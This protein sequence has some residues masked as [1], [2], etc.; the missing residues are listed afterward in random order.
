MSAHRATGLATRCSACGTVFRVVPDQ[1]RVSEGWVRCG[2][3]SEV[4]NAL[5]GLVDL[6]TGL[7][8]RSLGAGLA[9]AV[10]DESEA[11]ESQ[12]GEYDYAHPAARPG[13]PALAPALASKP[14][15]AVPPPVRH[16]TIQEDDSA[17]NSSL[18]T[19]PDFSTQISAEELAQANA[20]PSFVANADRAALWRRPRVRGVLVLVGLLAAMGLTA[21]VAHEYRNLVAAA[22]PES[23]PWLEQACAALNC[24]VEAAQAIENLAVESS[25][26]VR[27]EKS[28]LYRLQVGLRN[29]AGIDL[30]VPALDVTLTDSQGRLIARKVLRAAEL[31]APQATI[32][33]GRELNLQATLQAATAAGGGEPVQPIAGYTIEL[34]YP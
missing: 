27:V 15:P 21:Q 29:R 13:A 3:C 17:A 30:A 19:R 8:K 34:F 7:P 33:A 5:E 6:E 31:G 9:P 23:R 26:L 25:G 32:G 20:K 18:E 28:N 2:R 22:W 12:F 11:Q 10:G 1:L 4:F 24:K 16:A 14:Q